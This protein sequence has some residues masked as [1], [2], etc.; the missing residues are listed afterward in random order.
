VPLRANATLAL[1]APGSAPNRAALLADDDPTKYELVAQTVKGVEPGKVYA[2]S[3]AIM[4]I[5]LNNSEGGGGATVCVQW[6]DTHGKYLGGSFPAGILSG[7]NWKTVGDSF[8][9]PT[10]A[11]PTSVSITVYVRP[12]SAGGA[13][14]TGI[15]YFDNVT[16]IHSPQPPLKSVLLAPNYRGRVTAADPTPITVRARLDFEQAETV[17]LVADL[18]AKVDGKPTGL[19][20]ATK[21]LGPFKV[22]GGKSEVA[23][24]EDWVD[25]AF[26]QIDARTALKPGEYI[27]S[28]TCLVAMA[29]FA[30]EFAANKSVATQLHNITR[31]D[32]TVQPPT[33]YIDRQLR[34]I[35]E[36]KPFWPMGL[37]FSTGLMVQ[38]NG[39][40][41]PAL[42]NISASLALDVKV[43]LT[44]P[45]IF[46]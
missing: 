44:P 12:T 8:Q 18:S 14:P 38:L 3:A 11:S 33:V 2:F 21:E 41:H 27:V 4:T 31:M 10:A 29:Y 40:I 16:L 23:L 36:G 30:D 9:L 6:E 28:V 20:I 22:S 42:A 7:G 39:S 1:K 24:G 34:T 15:A 35:V 25:L 43:I 45:C 46:Y 26:D 19:P 17:F 5:G 13:V 32:D 37:Y